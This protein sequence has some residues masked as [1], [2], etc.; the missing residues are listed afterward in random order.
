MSVR[1]LFALAAT[2]FAV[3]VLS[4]PAQSAEWKYSS[5]TPPAAINN[6]YGT[7]P[8]IKSVEA[9]TNKGFS[10]QNFMGAQLFNNRTTLKGVGDG[11][12]DA[13]VIVPAFT[14]RELKHATIIPDASVLFTDPWTS[15]PAANEAL[16]RGL[17]PELMEDFREN[18]TVSLGVYG[19]GQDTMQCAVD[20]ATLNDLRGLKMA[21]VSSSMARWA[22]QLGQA[23]QQIGPGDLLPALQRRQVDCTTSPLEFLVALSLKDAVKTIIDKPLGAFPAIHLMVVNRKSWE[24]LDPEYKKVLLEEM[25]KAI[26]RIVAAYLNGETNARKLAAEKG[27]KIIKPDGLDKLWS[28]FIASE[29]SKTIGEL[30]KARGV[31]EDVSKKVIDEHL[32]LVDKWTAIMDR[33][34]RTEEGLAKAMWEEIYSKLDVA[35]L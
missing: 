15:T 8:L 2:L 33:V 9:R 25:P 1:Y 13:G 35:K 3:P 7:I 22:E 6:A 20:V 17:T 5:W 32:K 12:A 10:I 11:A 19:G 14:A 21:G 24:S 18:G 16:L 23:R 34:G 30:A 4:G 26:A 28:D 27:I 31:S 29:R